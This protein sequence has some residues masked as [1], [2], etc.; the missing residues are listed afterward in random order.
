MREHQYLRTLRH[1]MR[2]PEEV[3]DFL[4]WNDVDTLADLMQ[5]TEE[6]LASIARDYGIDTSPVRKYL[7]WYGLELCHCDGRTYKVRTL[8]LIK[9]PEHPVWETWEY[10]IDKM[11]RDIC[12]IT[13]C[14]PGNLVLDILSGGAN[15][16]QV[17][18]RISN[19]RIEMPGY[20]EFELIRPCSLAARYH[21]NNCPGR[22][23]LE[24]WFNASVKQIVGQYPP[25]AYI[26]KIA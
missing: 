1:E 15:G 23:Q 2:L 25:F 4:Y 17:E 5:I 18:L 20:V 6:E 14:G 10:F 24:A 11:G 19:E 12:K 8:T 7:E 21:V 9:N 16:M 26:R 3:L 13:S 22:P